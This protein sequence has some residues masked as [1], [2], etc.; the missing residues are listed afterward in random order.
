MN[1]NSDNWLL[2]KGGYDDCGITSVGGAALE[3]TVRNEPTAEIDWQRFPVKEM[4]KRGWVACED[5]IQEWFDKVPEWKR[6]CPMY[7]RMRIRSSKRVDPYSLAAWTARIVT[8]SRGQALRGQFD[9]KSID[10]LLMTDLA[11]L[12]DSETGPQEAIGRLGQ[13]GIA[14]V[15]EPHLPR[16]YLDGAALFAGGDTAII[17]LT[18]RYDRIDNFWYCLMHE[19]AH[20]ALHV[21]DDR[22]SQFFDDLDTSEEI[23]AREV[24]ADELAFE[25]L[26]PKVAWDASPAKLLPSKEAAELLAKE[27]MIHPAIVAGRM[28]FERSYT[29]LSQLVGNGGIRYQFP[30]IEWS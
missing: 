15:V 14:V 21:G 26:I 16:T 12:S 11:K 22:D 29:F 17:G 25:A 4:V 28:R 5:A 2:R 10:L 9:S 23:D 24:E 1:M 19:L 20:L 27:L 3:L 18:I 13:L 7:H 30:N 8:K 6:F